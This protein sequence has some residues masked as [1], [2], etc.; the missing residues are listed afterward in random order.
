MGGSQEGAS[1]AGDSHRF[2]SAAEYKEDP[3]RGAMLN[4][5]EVEATPGQIAILN[6]A[7]KM[8]GRGLQVRILS[9][10]FSN[11]ALVY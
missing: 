7:R 9:A 6:Q 8:F 1:D 2:H 3:L 5:V 10:L 4:F 11:L